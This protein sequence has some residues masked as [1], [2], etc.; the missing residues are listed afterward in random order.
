MAIE[1]KI[2]NIPLRKKVI[3]KRKVGRAPY[4]MRLIKRYLETHTKKTDIKLGRHLNEAM[5]TR[6]TKKP[7][8][9]I[10]VRAI[11][12]GNTVKAELFGKDYADF[13]VISA[14]KREKMMDKLRARIGDKASQNEDLEK[15]IDGK[16]E[17]EAPSK[18]E[19][20][21][22]LE[23]KEEPKKAEPEKK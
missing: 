18:T 20:K 4:A 7:P 9:R 8:A 17:K 16:V 14:P 10:R 3:R 15:K 5:W 11:I 22:T 6:G 21:K 1:E 13:K 2:Y 23:K 19:A 12:E